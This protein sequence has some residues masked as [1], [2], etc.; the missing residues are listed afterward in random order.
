MTGPEIASN[1]IN[2]AFIVCVFFAVPIV[3]PVVSTL[4]VLLIIFGCL[5]A[6]GT[7]FQITSAYK[8]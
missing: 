4:G 7:M 3:M 8:K 5:Y 6:L 2:I 1:I